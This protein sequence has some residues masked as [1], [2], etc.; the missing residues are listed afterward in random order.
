MTATSGGEDVGPARP[1][2]E[3]SSHYQIN[4]LSERLYVVCAEYCVGYDDVENSFC[5]DV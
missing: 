3:I 2:N 4:L 1:T 5:G